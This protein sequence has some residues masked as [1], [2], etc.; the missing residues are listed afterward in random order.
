MSAWGFLHMNGEKSDME[1]ILL[2]FEYIYKR[3]LTDVK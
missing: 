2:L 3:H 1:I